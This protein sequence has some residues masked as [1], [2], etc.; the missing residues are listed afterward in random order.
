MKNIT[1]AQA[2]ESAKVLNQ[3]CKEQVSC[4]HCPFCNGS[5]AGTYG[6]KLQKQTISNLKFKEVI[7]WEV[8]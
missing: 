8:E 3:F 6:C 2:I 5:V 1:V 7:T 4:G